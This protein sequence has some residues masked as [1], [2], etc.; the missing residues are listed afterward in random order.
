VRNCVEISFE[1]LAI[2]DRVVI[3]DRDHNAYGAHG[4]VYWLDKRTRMISVVTDGN[5]DTWE[6]MA[7]ALAKL[8]ETTSEQ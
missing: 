2:N 1:Q 6:G 4:M 3:L 8:V 7:D 5:V